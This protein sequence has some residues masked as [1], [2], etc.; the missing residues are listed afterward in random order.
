MHCV[1]NSTTGPITCADTVELYT[2]KMLD[3]AVIC[4]VTW[5]TEKVDDCD[6]IN[7]VECASICLASAYGKETRYSVVRALCGN[8]VLVVDSQNSVRLCEVVDVCV[9]VWGGGGSRCYR[10]FG[11][12]CDIDK[13]LG[14]FAKGFM[15]FIDGVFEGLTRTE[16]LVTVNVFIYTKH[17]L[18]AFVRLFKTN[19]LRYFIKCSPKLN[20]G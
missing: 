10:Y 12:S 13:C 7:D 11:C 3:L 9:C 6:Q 5:P 17:Q 2:N 4:H 8:G 14:S 19:S 20:K 15:S 1:A 16:N 18:V